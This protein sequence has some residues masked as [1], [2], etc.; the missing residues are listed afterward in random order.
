MK[1]ELFILLLFLVISFCVSAQN[2]LYSDIQ[3]D[4]SDFPE[5]YEV[6]SKMKEII[7]APASEAIAAPFNIFIQEGSNTNVRFQVKRQRNAFYL[8]FTNEYN[9]SYP[10]YS[11]GSYIIKRS[12]KDGSIIQVKIFIKNDPGC[13][14]RIFRM[15][16]RSLMDL[17]LYNH[18]VYKNVTIP[19]SFSRVMYEP[20]SRI[21]EVSKNSIDWDIVL[22][23]ESICFQ[24]KIFNIVEKIREKLPDL[25]DID[26][27]AMDSN[28][29]FVLIDDLSTQEEEGFNCSGFAKWVID[30]IY[31]SKTGRNIDIAVLKEKHTSLRGNNWSERY[32][33][34]RDPYFGLDWTRNLAAAVSTADSP[35]SAASLEDADVRDVPSFRYIEDVGYPVKELKLIMYL[36]AVKNPGYFYLGS[37]NRQFGKDPI[38][39]QHIHVVVF[40]PYITS[41]GDFRFSIMERNRETTLKSFTNRYKNDYIHLVRIE[42]PDNYKLPEL[43]S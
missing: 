11:K 19:I 9:Y 10:L 13:F 35:V 1:K 43:N 22:P 27:G 20:F 25:K 32:E 8:L 12:R 18:P 5:N 34:D 17:Y 28:G 40:F 41:S 33:D 24:K 2:Y 21:I 38:L 6:R 37:V 3:S 29:N 26:D 36:L 42:V 30:G 7:F 23:A 15:G 14:V 39:R 4:Y 31:Y 16:E